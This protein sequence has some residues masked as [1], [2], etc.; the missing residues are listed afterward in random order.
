MNKTV[1][2]WIISK[3]NAKSHLTAI[4]RKT[5]SAPL[6]ELIARDLINGPVLDYGS[7]HGADVEE[8]ERLGID[9]TAYDPYNGISTD[10]A[11]FNSSKFKTILCTYVLN[12]VN[13]KTRDDIIKDI[14]NSL[15]PDGIAY[16]TVRRD[17]KK[18]GLTKRG[19]EQFNVKLN[20]SK[21]KENSNF[22]IYRLQ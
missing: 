22:C 21:V 12:V 2:S 10:R 13:K 18:E 15:S 4:H 16:V 7:G 14:R 8:L 1:G 20:E 19:T 11:V 9:S 17:I 5:M 6:S 3:M